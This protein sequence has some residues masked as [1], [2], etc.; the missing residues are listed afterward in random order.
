M[1][2]YVMLCHVMLCFVIICYVILCYVMLCYVVS[3]SRRLQSQ[4]PRRSLLSCLLSCPWC[5]H[6]GFFSWSPFSCVLAFAIHYHQRQGL[7]F[8]DIKYVLCYIMFCYVRFCYVVLCCV[9]LCFVMLCFVMWCYVVLCC[10]M[11]CCVIF[12]Y[13]TL[14]YV[15]SWSRREQSQR[16]RPNLLCCLWCQHLCYFYWVLFSF[17]LALFYIITK[18]RVN[19]FSGHSILCY[20]M[21]CY[22]KLCFVMSCHVMLSFIVLC[23]F[24]LCYV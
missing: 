7:Y 15:V 2:C 6:L 9:V 10:V 24:M 22:L 16:S 5:Q 20:V 23:Y 17:D 19:L 12:C 3:W 4:R 18:D 14:C 1:L 13:V 21:L 11:L 8:K